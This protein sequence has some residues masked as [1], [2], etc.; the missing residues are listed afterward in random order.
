VRSLK[1]LDMSRR[2]VLSDPLHDPTQ[3]LRHPQI[4]PRNSASEEVCTAVSHLV[5]AAT[6]NVKI[7]KKN[8]SLKFDNH[9]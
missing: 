9:F 2:W 7:N 3:K 4:D 6:L 5:S 8:L 1:C